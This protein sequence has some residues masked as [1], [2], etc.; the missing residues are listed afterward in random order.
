[1][2][3]SWLYRLQTPLSHYEDWYD[4]KR[5]KPNLQ[6]K[7]LKMI[8][9]KGRLAICEAESY[10]GGQR[11]HK[12]VS[13]S[14]KILKDKGLI[15]KMTDRN[16]GPGRFIGKGMP[17]NYYTV[18]EYGLA[19]LIKQG[20]DPSE[21]WNALITYSSGKSKD[22][23]GLDRIEGIYELYLQQYL[24]Y[25]TGF[26]YNVVLQ[27]DSFNTMC[28]EWIAENTSRNGPIKLEQKV[29]EILA[30]AGLPAGM[31]IQEI[32]ARSKE[33]QEN[34]RKV[35]RQYAPVPSY[36]SPLLTEE[37]VNPAYRSL[38]LDLED[39]IQRN[40]ITVQITN[41]IEKYSL[42]L[43]GILLVLTLV[44]YHKMNR[45]N[46]YLLGNYSIQ[47]AFDIV[48]TNYKN[49]LPLI[50]GQWDT[51][52]DILKVLSVYNFEVII[53]H[54]ARSKFLETPVVLGGNKEY[55]EANRDIAIYNRMQMRNLYNVG[56]MALEHFHLNSEDKENNN[57]YGK[58]PKTIA[59]YRKLV[60][61]GV[62]LGYHSILSSDNKH[63]LSYVYDID[64]I[65]TTWVLERA[66]AH[67][68]TFLYYLNLN[69]DIYVSRL[70]PEYSLAP[71]KTKTL[72]KSP[73]ERLVAILKKRQLVKEWF[74]NCI[75]NCIR[76][77]NAADEVM[78]T[79]YNDFS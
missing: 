63:N 23:Q 52:K 1:M 73:K 14:F 66:F 22:D 10:L 25:S 27:L 26:D 33:D 18:T 56:I 7:I 31:T 53:D 28:K 60:E 24:K 19:A 74:S 75:S 35:L 78:S 44:S 39:T 8:T 48:A 76:F 32:S 29:L 21:F 43:F 72:L 9:N 55:Y 46:L 38:E 71:P 64:D 37:E 57:R 65:P 30:L 50:F 58:N 68:I 17:R 34:V 13:Q 40:I 49:K 59:I 42:S 47:E 20:L 54:R 5:R 45:R 12:E 70:F 77:R 67:E 69:L 79:F 61:I 11:I 4:H 6:I 41:K 36:E 62:L 2:G 51:L 16:P 15:E 3:F